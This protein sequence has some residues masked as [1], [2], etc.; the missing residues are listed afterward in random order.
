MTAAATQKTPRVSAKER[1]VLDMVAQRGEVDWSRAHK[2]TVD[3]LQRKGL[4]EARLG[5]DVRGET[6]A[7][8]I[9][10][11]A[12]SAVLAA[13]PDIFD[14]LFDDLFDQPQEKAHAMPPKQA[15]TTTE[16]QKARK[17]QAALARLQTVTDVE[18]DEH[19]LL[20]DEQRR[21]CK[22]LRRA[23]LREERAFT[24]LTFA[25]VAL[26]AT[27]NDYAAVSDEGGPVAAKRDREHRR[28]AI[29]YA[30]EAVRCGPAIVA[31]TAAERGTL[32]DLEILASHGLP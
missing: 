1:R 28:A 9:I 26:R 10:T 7:Q 3:S 6:C 24:M 8:R 22:A 23:A 32:K 5:R 11:P 20:D 21:I 14:D 4:L 13:V 27:G 30:Y 2:N 15:A 19:P 25:E 12:G 17:A 18:I 16:S 29:L 31:E